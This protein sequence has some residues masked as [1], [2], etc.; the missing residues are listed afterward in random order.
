MMKAMKKI[1]LTLAIILSFAVT[2]PVLA[3]TLPPSLLVGDSKNSAVF[4]QWIDVP[5]ATNYLIEYKPTQGSVWSIFPHE[6]STTSGI[7]IPNLTNG[8]SYDFRVSTIS[9]SETSTPSNI[10]TV[11]P[12]HEW[13]YN[14]S[15]NH[16]ISTGQSLATG[17]NSFPALTTTQPYYN[18]MLSVGGSS[19]SPL[20]ETIY[21]GMPGTETMSSS[22]ANS[23]SSYFSPNYSTI[24]SMHAQNAASYLEIKQ[25]TPAYENAL[26]TIAS[27]K[28]ISLFSN[29]KTLVV[30][31]FTVIHGETDELWNTTA[32]QYEEYLVEWQQDYESDIQAITGQSESVL[33]FT[34][35]MSSWTRFNFATPRI[36]IG[37]YNAAKNNPDNIIM[38]APKYM[39]DYFDGYHLRNYSTRRLGEYYAKVYKKVVIDGEEWK[40]LMPEEITISG[41]E[42]LARFHVPVPPLAFDTTA[43]LAKANYGFEYADDTNS[44][45]ITDVEIISGDTVKITLNTTPTGNNQRLRYA[46]T[47]E[48]A[49][50]SGSQWPGS[51]R[52]NLRDSDMTEAT[53]Q[54][55]NVP[56]YM[57]NYLHNW[58]L[59]FDE[60]IVQALSVPSAPT[61][62]TATLGS[63][64]GTAVVSFTIPNGGP[65][66]TNYIVTSIPGNI[67][68][69]GTTSP[70][71]VA[72]LSNNTTYT[73]SVVAVNSAGESA[74]ALSN[75]V[76][77]NWINPNVVVKPRKPIALVN[78]NKRP[79]RLESEKMK[80]SE[81]TKSPEMVEKAKSSQTAT[82]LDSL[83]K[84]PKTSDSTEESVASTE[85]ESKR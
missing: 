71:T 59:T 80:T 41:N 24:F 76:T 6:Q 49:S 63:V 26:N 3:D 60:Q 81:I 48:P 38:V 55:S 31:A 19:F 9:G 42:I 5:Q 72:G 47:G 34:D 16:I 57:G 20:Q 28:S 8:T 33:M 14:S 35:Q 2:S 70:I 44:A 54:D 83:P 43:V 78:T 85:I 62:V 15:N 7:T 39:L 53:Y 82:V 64:S 46:Y 45:T 10:I 27:S 74:P 61:S 12:S 40:P 66:A 11:E 50:M 58:A 23:I 36:A 73:F 68:F 56:A 75:S 17:Y 67:V 21:G 37:Q 25:G 65:V 13:I 77:T 51:A 1:F 29:N 18:K 32:E 22:M 84:I 69:N 52:G 79:I 4:L 30:P